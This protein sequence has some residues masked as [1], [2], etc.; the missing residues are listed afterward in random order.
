MI[1]INRKKKERSENLKNKPW[2][3]REE[4]EEEEEK[5][6]GKGRDWE[7]ISLKV[8]FKLLNV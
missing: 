6:R 5:I 7:E 2:E 8:R 3:R 1:N 4:E